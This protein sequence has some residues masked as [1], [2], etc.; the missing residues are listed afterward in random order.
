[1]LKYT[2]NYYYNI[3]SCILS[4]ITFSSKLLTKEIEQ[5]KSFNYTDETLILANMLF[6]YKRWSKR[7]KRLIRGFYNSIADIKETDYG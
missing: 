5:Q 3:F 2:N 4:Y 1:M 7:R 6:N